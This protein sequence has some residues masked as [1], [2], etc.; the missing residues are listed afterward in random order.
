[1]LER[2]GPPPNKWAVYAVVA[3]GVL[4]ATLDSSIVNISLP[5]I[6]R[7]FG[8]PLGG[9]LS[10][11]VIAYLVVIVSLLLTGG[12]L[13]DLLGRK[14][15]WQIGLIVFALSSAGCGLAPSL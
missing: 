11:V 9:V 15:V 3:V 7:S 12:R 5:S 6:A 2:E 4:M 14:R 8:R 10:W 13:G 1:M